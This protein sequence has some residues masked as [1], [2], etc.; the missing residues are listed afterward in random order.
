MA[1]IR[2]IAFYPS[3]PFWAGS[4]IDFSD[5]KNL[6]NFENLMAEEVLSESNDTFCLKVCR[7]GMVMLRLEALETESGSRLMPRD[8]EFTVKKW[9]QY[10]DFLNSFYLLL[11]S[12]TM[13]YMNFSYFNL[14]E[15]TNRDAFEVNYENGKV[16]GQVVAAESVTSVFQMARIKATY[17]RFPIRNHPAIVTRRVISLEAIANA[18]TEFGHVVKRP[19]LEKVLATF[20]KS[21]AEY[22]VG[23]YETSIMLAWFISEAVIHKMWETCINSLLE[24]A[25][26]VQQ[27]INSK[28]KHFLRGRDFPV[29]VV[30]NI[31]ELFGILSLKLF[32]D[33]NTVRGWRNKII[34]RD[35][36]YSPK[37]NDAHLA[38]ATALELSRITDGIDFTPS[39]SYSIAGI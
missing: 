2:F 13:R 22:K 35:P 34:H 4:E 12:S 11:D 28:R 1:T 31:L 33:V 30:T 3:R 32:K 21:L 15:I 9:G 36:A 6:D 8:I 20:T 26:E 25:G 7:D 19:G 24:D 23:N 18:V 16:A 27:R 38:I 14:H 37:A 5:P 39:F 17:G 10:L 29:A